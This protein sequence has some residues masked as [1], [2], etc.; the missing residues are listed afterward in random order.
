M[1]TLLFTYFYFLNK[2]HQ[3]AYF[4]IIMPRNQTI[5]KSPN[6][7]PTTLSH[8]ITQHY[9]ISKKQFPLTLLTKLNVDHFFYEKHLN[10][11][12]TLIYEWKFSLPFKS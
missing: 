11:L 1:K 3:L 9:F 4:C 2:D 12:E 8:V 7:I 10:V 6:K 5:N